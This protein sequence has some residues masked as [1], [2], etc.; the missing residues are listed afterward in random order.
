MGLRRTYIPRIVKWVLVDDSHPIFNRWLSDAGYIEAFFKYENPNTVKPYGTSCP[1]NEQQMN[2]RIAR[3]KKA[4]EKLN[5][6]MIV[7]AQ[8]SVLR[9]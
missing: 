2:E 4:L 6:A 1:L 9:G 5:D 7:N 8:T 3:E